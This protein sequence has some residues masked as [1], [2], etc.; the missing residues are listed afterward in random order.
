MFMT[1][2]FPVPGRK[3]AASHPSRLLGSSWDEDLR[4]E[5]QGAAVPGMMEYN[6]MCV[7]CPL[8]WTNEKSYLSC[9]TETLNLSY[10]RLSI[11]KEAICGVIGRRGQ[12][13]WAEAF[14]RN[15]SPLLMPYSGFTVGYFKMNLAC[16][17]EIHCLTQDS[18]EISGK[19][20]IRDLEG[21]GPNT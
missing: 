15:W 19:T 4:M 11:K 1:H 12:M 18:R 9:F 7:S 6:G 21:L 14:L 3:V 8:G 2:L 20:L 5:Q 10:P 13:Q 16:Q 17:L